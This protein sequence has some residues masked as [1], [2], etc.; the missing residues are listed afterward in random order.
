MFI[1]TAQGESPE[2][3][4]TWQVVAETPMVL[5]R[6]ADNDYAVPW[7]HL[8]SRKHAELTLTSQSLALRCLPGTHN[9]IWHCGRSH[10]ETTIVAGE[11]FQVGRT[12]FTLS[13][14]ARPLAPL[15]LVDAG[16]AQEGQKTST[17]MSPSDIRMA[18]VSQNTT[19]LWMAA[20]EKELAQQALLVL[21]Q[22]LTGADLLVTLNCEDVQ[23]ANRP[24]IIHWQKT[25]S[26]VQAS[27]GRDLI[28]R[29]VKNDE[30][31]IQV[32]SDAFG[33]PVKTGWWSFCVPVRSEAAIPWCIYVGGMFGGAAEYPAFLKP[34]QLKSDASVTELVA[35]MMGAVRSVRSLESRFEGMRRFFRLVCLTPF[36]QMAPMELTLLLVKRILLPSTAIFEVSLA[37]L[38]IRR[39]ICMACCVESVPPLAS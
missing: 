36:P 12:R 23:S 6:S 38:R 15:Q 1:L 17:L 21:Q 30:T 8:V 5:G 32:E 4:E 35:H 16:E 27:I 11:T 33:E 34:H 37:W 18:V 25:E 14:S 2:H 22:V 9:P 19:A 20:D 28:A 29:S 10:Q 39:T 24:R 13:A 7:D 3:N 26:G 31:A